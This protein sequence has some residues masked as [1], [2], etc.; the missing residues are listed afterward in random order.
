[1]SSVTGPSQRTGIILGA[2][3]WETGPS[4]TL[5]RRTR[6]AAKLYHENKIGHLVVCGGLGKHPPTEAAAM[7]EILLS[8]GVPSNVITQEKTSAT[9]G[10]N[11]FNA[12][13]L[14]GNAPILI[15]TDWY[16]APRARLIA[17]R[18]NFS[19]VSCAAPPLESARLWPQIKGALREIPAYAAYY[20]RF[21]S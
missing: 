11:L 14:I 10:E 18:A 9:T 4:P 2:A 3:V 21:K 20:F 6:H 8:E 19:Q 7:A 1:M 16:H 5:L 17:R 13:S 15:I 12:H